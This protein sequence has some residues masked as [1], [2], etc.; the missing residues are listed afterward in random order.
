MV[1]SAYWWLLRLTSKPL[2]VS[3]NKTAL[4]RVQWAVSQQ[5]RLCSA[6]YR[7]ALIKTQDKNASAKRSSTTP[8]RASRRA[9]LSAIRGGCA[10]DGSTHA[11]GNTVRGGRAHDGGAPDRLA[12]SRW[13]PAAAPARARTARAAA[14]AAHAAASAAA[15]AL[16][17]AL[18]PPSLFA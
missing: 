16:A 7:D 10:H 2:K 9:R 11:S 4:L 6:L 1:A 18:A 5:T 14:A 8:K 15:A 13:R 12:D 3:D 17:A